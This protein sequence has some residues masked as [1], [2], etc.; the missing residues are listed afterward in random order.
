MCR[1]DGCVWLTRSGKM[2][3]VDGCVLLYLWP[4]SA[5]FTLVDRAPIHRS[6]A[7]YTWTVVFCPV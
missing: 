7:G 6:N 1:G 2:E 4:L 3:A 5:L